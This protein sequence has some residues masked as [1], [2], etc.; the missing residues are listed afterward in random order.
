[1]LKMLTKVRLWFLYKCES[2]LGSKGFTIILG[3]VPNPPK[4]GALDP[5]LYPG[6]HLLE[7]TVVLICT[8]GI[9]KSRNPIPLMDPWCYNLSSLIDL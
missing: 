2:V 6:G 7:S 8:G 1:M 4:D 9:Y 3:S 5:N